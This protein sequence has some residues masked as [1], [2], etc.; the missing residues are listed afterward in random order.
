MLNST[1]F[2]TDNEIVKY[3]RILRENHKN[4]MR[5][6]QEA[7]LKKQELVLPEHSPKFMK[8]LNVILCH[9]EESIE[10]ICPT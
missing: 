2:P 5:F 10:T 4:V 8:W 3:F 7:V 6:A 1:G 9:D